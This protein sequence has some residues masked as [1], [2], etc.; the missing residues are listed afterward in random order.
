MT[1]LEFAKEVKKQVEDR[2]DGTYRVEV[3]EIRKNNNVKMTGLIVLPENLNV[4]PTIYLDSFFEAYQ[5]GTEMDTIVE[6]LL[7]LYWEGL[8]TKEIDM[9]F[10]KDYEKVKDKICYR[11]IHY[12]MNKEFLEKVPYI[13]FLDLAIV[14]FYSFDNEQI[15]KGTIAIYNS[16]K[17]T[18]KVSNAE[19]LERAKENTTR[20]Y[21]S[22]V[23]PMTDVLEMIMDRGADKDLKDSFYEEKEELLETLPMH[24]L[25][26]TARF[27]GAI[28]MLYPEVLE[29]VFR[30]TNEGFYILP[31]SI[32]EGATC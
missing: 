32:H 22:E 3:Q 30:E 5:N 27:L 12:E 8:P 25:S 21:P 13:P 28:C 15:G 7:Q 24:V 9:D 16:H 10:F 31:S 2:L 20:L 1:V 11:L 23:L 4:S 19:L 14:F 26:N 18:W 29:N 6:S 17:E